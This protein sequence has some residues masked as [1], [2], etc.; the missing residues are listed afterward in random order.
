MARQFGEI[1]GQPEGGTYTN[2]R[3][4]SIV[5]VH[6]PLQ[7]GISGGESDGADSIVV[8]GG[9]EDDEDHG[10][11]ILYTGHGG[12][13]P[14]ARKQVADQELTA[15]NL[16][17]A[18]NATDGIPVRVIRGAGGDPAYSPKAG[19]RYDGLY[20]VES[21]EEKTGKSGYRIFRYK[22]AK[23][24]TPADAGVEDESA[25]EDEETPGATGPAPRMPTTIQRIVRNTVMAQAVKELHNHRCQVCGERV[26]TPAGPYAEG[27]HIRPLGRPHHGPDVAGNILCLCPTD[28]VRFD[29]G[30]VHVLDDLTIWDTLAEVGVGRLRTVAKHKVDAAALAYHRQIRG[31]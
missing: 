20:R 6:R 19:F 2:R 17:L 25:P 10:D 16:A 7:A 29:A 3:G 30:A 14:A 13:D 27:A 5:G 26:E 12:N 1:P 15:G 9:Y 31:G 22:L 21:Y 24:G 11:V 28:H 4:L 23:L 8:S 18:R